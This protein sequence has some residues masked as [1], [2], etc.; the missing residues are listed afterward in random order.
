MITTTLISR[1][2]F[3]TLQ[4]VALV[5]RLAFIAQLAWGDARS[6][7]FFQF[8]HVQHNHVLLVFHI[9]HPLSTPPKIA[10]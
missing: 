1:L 9:F 2:S 4:A 7:A 6:N 3:V 8:F 10:A 5:S